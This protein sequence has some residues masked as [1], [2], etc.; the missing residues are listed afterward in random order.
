MTKKLSRRQFATAAGGAVL[1]SAVAP[2]MSRAASAAP[3][4]APAA[5][6]AYT[7]RFLTQYNKIKDPAN[8]YFS[9]QGIPYHCV[10]TLIVEA[11]DYGHQTTSEAF[12]LLDVA[13]GDCTAR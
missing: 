10:E 3:A 9:A 13:R 5:T 1:A 4:A 8:G 11:P 7:Q 6:D 2:S 12:S